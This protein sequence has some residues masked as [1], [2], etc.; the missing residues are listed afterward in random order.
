MIYLRETSKVLARLS[1]EEEMNVSISPLHLLSGR[2][3]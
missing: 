3:L 1:Y 2:K